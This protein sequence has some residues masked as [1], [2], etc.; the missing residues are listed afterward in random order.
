MK[1]RQKWEGRGWDRQRPQG[2]IGEIE[3]G[4][5]HCRRQSYAFIATSEHLGLVEKRGN[6]YREKREGTGE[7]E[8]REK[9]KWRE[10]RE[11]REYITI[12]F[13]QHLSV[14]LQICNGTVAM[15]YNLWDLAHLIKLHFCVW[16]GKC[17]KYM[18]FGTFATPIVKI[19]GT[20]ATPI[21]NA[22]IGA[23]LC[24]TFDNVTVGKARISIKEK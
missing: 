1:G 4:E 12:K 16:C 17:A 18:T 22:L 8:R 5:A 9:K 20:L 15:L 2:E 19:F 23:F 13:L 10:R 7:W 3:H 21:V 24:T 6:R 14:S 11:K